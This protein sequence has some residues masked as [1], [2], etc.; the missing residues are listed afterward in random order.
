MAKIDT[1]KRV[2]IVTGCSEINSLGAAFSKELLKRG[3]TV[4][5]TARKIS[6]LSALEA[7]GCQIVELD[8]VSDDSVAAAIKHVTTLTGGRVDLLINNV[9]EDLASAPL[10]SRSS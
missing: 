5:A 8:V 6:T 9:S 1:S 4:F 2:A 3:W 7:A 10:V